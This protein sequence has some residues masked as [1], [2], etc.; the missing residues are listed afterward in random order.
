MVYYNS[1]NIKV[2]TR[3]QKE[4]IRKNKISILPYKG[5]KFVKIFFSR[6]LS[7]TSSYF[8]TKRIKNFNEDNLEIVD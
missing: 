2:R 5:E 3:D 7:H 1:V 8:L 4:I 6:L